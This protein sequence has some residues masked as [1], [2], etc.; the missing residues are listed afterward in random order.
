MSITNEPT[1]RE[2]IANLVETAIEAERFVV[3]VFWV[4]SGMVYHGWEVYNWLNGDFPQLVELTEVDTG[5]LLRGESGRT[6]PIDVMAEP[7]PAEEG[8]DAART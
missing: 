4:N 5:K 7:P 2:N 6:T 3:S 8:Q 1:I